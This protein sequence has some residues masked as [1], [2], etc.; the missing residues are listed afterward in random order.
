MG[1]GAVARAH[2]GGERGDGG[3]GSPP[4]GGSPGGTDLRQR[5]SATPRLCPVVGAG[6]AGRDH[7]GGVAMKDQFR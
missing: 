5:L 2:A 4:G 7:F 6:W 1:E 3:D